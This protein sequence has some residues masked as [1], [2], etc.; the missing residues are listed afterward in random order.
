MI[1][2]WSI[3][4][5]EHELETFLECIWVLLWQAAQPLPHPAINT[6]LVAELYEQA[7]MLAETA[8]SDDDEPKTTRLWKLAQHHRHR[9]ARW[10]EEMFEIYE[11]FAEP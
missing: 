5:A 8:A 4:L 10:R 9:L 11:T 3:T 1:S 2:P 6:R 7:I